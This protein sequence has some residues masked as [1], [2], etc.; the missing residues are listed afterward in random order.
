MTTLPEYVEGVPNISGS[1][2]AISAAMA[3]GKS[4]S[5]SNSAGGVDFGSVRAAA[6]IALH[7][8]Q[9]LIPAGGDDL[10]TAEHHQQPQVHDGP[11][12]H[13]R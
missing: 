12:G 6:A 1:E 3:A 7:Q 8:H 10:R 5:L 4:K 13:R 2:A 9:P 11:P